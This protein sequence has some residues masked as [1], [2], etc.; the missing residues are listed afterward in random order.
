MRTALVGATV[1]SLLA[2]C[3]KRERPS[4]PASVEMGVRFTA[5]YAGSAANGVGAIPHRHHWLPILPALGESLHG[6]RLNDRRRHVPGR[7][8]SPGSR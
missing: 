3:Q 7:P 2:G 1:V 5:I 6:T 8:G 4:T